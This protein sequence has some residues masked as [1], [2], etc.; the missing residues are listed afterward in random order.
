MNLLKQALV[1]QIPHIF[2]LKSS[3][4]SGINFATVMEGA[5]KLTVVHSDPKK[6]LKIT[7][8]IGHV[9]HAYFR[10]NITGRQ[11]DVVYCPGTTT[12]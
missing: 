8:E 11:T 6:R 9:M 2:W 3:S 7:E 4:G 10:R 5:T 1:L 12:K